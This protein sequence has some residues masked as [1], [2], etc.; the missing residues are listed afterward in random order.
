MPSI[1]STPLPHCK[2]RLRYQGSD[3][4]GRVFVVSRQRVEIMRPQPYFTASI[5]RSPGGSCCS[6]ADGTAA[7]A[8]AALGFEGDFLADQRIHQYARHNRLLSAP[9]GQAIANIGPRIA[10]KK[11]QRRFR[12][13]N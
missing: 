10:W 3:H 9:I 12:S 6:S 13:S 2:K 8:A 4:R 1:A 5:K 7:A 11:N